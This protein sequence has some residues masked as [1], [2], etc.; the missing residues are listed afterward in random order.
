MAI[1]MH[2]IWTNNA[3]SPDLPLALLGPGPNPSSGYL[4][5]HGY[6]KLLAQESS[7][8]D[9]ASFSLSSSSPGL[10]RRS[11]RRKPATANL[12]QIC[13]RQDV[14]EGLPYLP[15]SSCS[16]AVSS[17]PSSPPPLSVVSSFS[18]S[19][20]T[21]RST[22]NMTTPPSS[23]ASSAVSPMVKQLGGLSSQSRRMVSSPVPIP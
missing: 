14:G 8:S 3:S 6:R 5:L 10:P 11:L 23:S 2:D 9:E 20:M 7:L 19:V 15:S 22:T 12:H 17:A 21:L 16:S 1:P 13:R 4:S 18:Q